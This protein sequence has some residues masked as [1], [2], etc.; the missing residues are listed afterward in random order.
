MLSF[1]RYKCD[2]K[3]NNSPTNPLIKRKLLLISFPII[4]SHQKISFL[5]LKFW[6]S[7]FISRFGSESHY[8]FKFLDWGWKRQTKLQKDLI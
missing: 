4:A 8:P 5:V 1:S 2:T 3:L 7:N 6:S